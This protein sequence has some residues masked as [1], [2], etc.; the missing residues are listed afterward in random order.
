MPLLLTYA[1][2][3]AGGPRNSPAPG[4]SGPP[5]TGGSQA[6][7]TGY[8]ETKAGCLVL[9]LDLS[10]NVLAGTGPFPNAALFF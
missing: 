10:S 8:A 2:H 7:V 9:S 5:G 4:Y 6:G 3:N 1:V